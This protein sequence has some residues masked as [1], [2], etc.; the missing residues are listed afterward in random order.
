[1]QERKELEAALLAAEAEIETEMRGVTEAYDTMQVYERGGRER[2]RGR[3]VCM[4]VCVCVCMCVCVCV[5]V[6]VCMCV[7]VYVCVCVC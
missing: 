2:P 6:Y 4:Y 7:C 5:C 3:G 1:M